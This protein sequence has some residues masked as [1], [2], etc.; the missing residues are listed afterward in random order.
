MWRDNNLGGR[1]M[2]P[3]ICALSACRRA[4]KPV[5]SRLSGTTVRLRHGTVCRTRFLARSN[6]MAG[7]WRVSVMMRFSLRYTACHLLDEAYV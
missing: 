6:V 2:G 1:L 4:R 7:F 3:V 5:Y